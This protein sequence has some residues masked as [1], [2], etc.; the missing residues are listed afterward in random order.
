MP[1]SITTPNNRKPLIARSPK[2][3][4]TYIVPIRERCVVATRMTGAPYAFRIASRSAAA[5][6]AIFLL[7]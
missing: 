1:I 3:S 2:L 5:I 4:L 7:A 6:S